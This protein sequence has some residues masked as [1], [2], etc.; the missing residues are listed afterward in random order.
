MA[1]EGPRRRRLANLNRGGTWVEEDPSRTAAQAQQQRGR[2][3]EL[4]VS[5]SESL[6][7][8]VQC[9]APGPPRVP[10]AA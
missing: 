10:Q 1:E 7:D 5:L 9:A 4:T 2:E 8:C 3:R 6:D